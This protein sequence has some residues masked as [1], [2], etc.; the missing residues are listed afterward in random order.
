MSRVNRDTHITS[1]KPAPC[2]APVIPHI[3]K[4][5]Q[6]AHPYRFSFVSG[7]SQPPKKILAGP[8]SQMRFVPG[9]TI[10]TI[11]TIA[12]SPIAVHSFL[13][14]VNH[15]R[16]TSGFLLAIATLPDYRL[17]KTVTSFKQSRQP[18][19]TQ[20]YESATNL[21]TPS[22]AHPRR[23]GPTAASHY[24]SNLLTEYRCMS[25]GLLH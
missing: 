25:E 3:N 20:A 22:A 6:P 21:S 8:T 5:R 13:R 16:N 19:R 1:Y 17:E 12:N 11:K 23:F 15:S 18:A 7:I 2:R 9:L 10:G 24:G 14:G 4:S